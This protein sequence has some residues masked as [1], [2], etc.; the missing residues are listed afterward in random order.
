MNFSGTEIS[1][2]DNE[3]SVYSHEKYDEV[4]LKIKKVQSNLSVVKT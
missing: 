4:V 1:L 3:R 2:F